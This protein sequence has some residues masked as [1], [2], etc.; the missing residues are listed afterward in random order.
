MRVEID[1][2]RVEAIQLI[3]AID[4]KL[5]EKLEK[6]LHELLTSV[7]GWEV[8]QNKKYS[9]LTLNEEI[10]KPDFW[11]PPIQLLTTSKKTPTGHKVCTTPVASK[12]EKRPHLRK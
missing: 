1:I 3:Q 5:F 11:Q 2:Q 7:E 12:P 9:I 8:E 6:C 4:G 10:S